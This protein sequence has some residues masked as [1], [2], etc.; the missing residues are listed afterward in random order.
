MAFFFFSFLNSLILLA[1][2]DTDERFLPLPAAPVVPDNGRLFWD[3][4]TGG[5]DA[6]PSVTEAEAAAPNEHDADRL[7]GCVVFVVVVAVV[8]IVGGSSATIVISAW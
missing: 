2:R 4:M 7:G 5:A 8:V 6:S 1:K 3:V